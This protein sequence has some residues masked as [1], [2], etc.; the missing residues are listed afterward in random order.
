MT[1]FRFFAVAA[2]GIGPLLAE[3]LRA[4]KA[5]G[6][7]E[8]AAGVAF[9]G[10]LS[11]GYAACL[12]SRTASRVLLE[13]KRF[14]ARDDGELYA[15][16]RAIPWDEHLK[17]SGTLLI[18]ANCRRSRIKHSQ[19]AAQRAKDAIVDQMR[20]RH[21]VRPNIQREHPDLRLNVFIDRDLATLYLDL[22]GESL[23][24]RGYRAQGG[25]APLKQNLAAAVLL[26]AG[27]PAIAAAGGALVDP[28]CGSGTLLIEGAW[29]ASDRAPG[30]LRAEF[31]FER[32]LQHDHATWKDLRGEAAARAEAGVARV[33]PILGYDAGE[34]AV[35]NAR[36]NI[37]AAGLTGKIEVRCVT[38]GD[39]IAERKLGLPAGAASAGNAEPSGASFADKHAAAEAGLVITNPPYGKRLGESDEL[40]S[41]YEQ[42]GTLLRT[43]YLGWQAAVLTGNPPFGKHVGIRARRVSTFYNGAIECRLLR[44]VLA[45]EHFVAESKPRELRPGA[46]MFANRLRKNLQTIGRWAEREGIGCYRLY[47]ADM[48]EYAAAVDLYQAERLYAVVQEYEAPKSID[49]NAARQRLRD[50]LH[51]L[52]ITLGLDR[53]QVILK[54]RARQRGSAQYQKLAERQEFH[55]VREGPCRLL[56]NFTDY[57]DTGLFLDHRITRRWVAEAASGRELL[58]LFCYTGTATVHAALAGARSS[59]S[60]DMS[61]PYLE[62]ARRNLVL[63]GIDAARHRLEE[64]DCLEWLERHARSTDERR[65][66]VIFLDP[67]TFSNSKRMEATLDIQR[68]HVRLLKQCLSLLEPDG[69]LF[70]STNRRHFKLR[71]EELT[72]V[73]IEDVSEQSVPRDFARNPHIHRCFRIRVVHPGR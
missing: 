1:E 29:M 13:L 60:V 39:L 7:G 64:A 69:E 12:W 6:V 36:A 20:S 3:E 38:L 57:L 47:D 62:W 42:L 41:A 24:R 34:R 56:V 22:S 30:L 67:P 45:P 73:S 26:R 21:G 54:H 52:P 43:R 71:A 50:M 31:G 65:Y 32:W 48:P 14:D 15:G 17:P 25:A 19:F 5:Q 72:G 8:V 63:N 23:N 66:G 49:P 4:L 46:Q 11:V 16:V 59:L 27:W 55:E 10:P 68:D 28:M 2:K 33:P 44:F 70:F 18:D 9:S 58:N 51:A 40:V 37:E 53:D 35:R 61:A